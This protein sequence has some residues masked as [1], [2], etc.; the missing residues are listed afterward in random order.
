[1][2][3]F[4]E[5]DK[6]LVSTKSALM[7]VDS[8]VGLNEIRIS[9]LGKSGTL[10]SILKQL[11]DVSQEDRPMVGKAVNDVRAEI[12]KLLENRGKELHQKALSEKLENEKIDITI[13]K[14]S[15]LQGGLH[16]LYKVKKLITD[17]F[18]NKGF[19]LVDSPEIETDYYNFQA[20]NTPEDHP[21]RDTQ[22]TFYITD[23]IL[24]RTQTSAGQIRTMEE[25]KPPIKIVSFGKVYRF[26]EIDA[27]HSAVFHQLEGLAVDKGITMCDLKGILSD[28][29][30][31][32]FGKDTKT[33]F[34]PSFFPFTEPSVEV[35]ATCPSCKGS[36]C[37]MCKGTGW[38]EILG[39]G[40]V[41]RNVLTN[42][43]IDPDVYTGFAFGIGI[44]R[45][46]LI[47]HSINDLRNVYENDVRF[48]KQFR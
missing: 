33:R 6:V 14:K 13:D 5:I 1:M 4:K 12:E 15:T 48:L 43:N 25:V 8:E 28:F 20:L 18:A 31:Y 22:D 21:A 11:K 2:D 7:S 42:C 3:V 10:T 34:R 45:V 23:N 37:R 39:A 35:D 19:M 9:V 29:A 30:K 26:D 46:S 16:P 44:D 40:M 36:G 24:L 41:N 32:F 27:T 38:M 17:Y 47:V